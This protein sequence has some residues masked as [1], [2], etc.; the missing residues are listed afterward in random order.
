MLESYR[1][2]FDILQVMMHHDILQFV[3]SSGKC[4]HN[5]PLLSGSFYT[6]RLSS[7]PFYKMFVELLLAEPLQAYVFYL[8]DTPAAIKQPDLS[9][10]YVFSPVGCY[11]CWP[12]WRNNK[13]PWV[14][15]LVLAPWTSVTPNT[16]FPLSGKHT[17]PLKLHTHAHK[18]HNHII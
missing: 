11:Y 12:G 2:Y 18:R 6:W 14:Y 4:S 1:V 16:D 3:L 7:Q 8:T 5:R 9:A 15:S 10:V 17:L 13:D